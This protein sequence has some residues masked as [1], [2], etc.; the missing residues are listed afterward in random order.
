MGPRQRVRS[1]GGRDTKSGRFQEDVGHIWGVVPGVGRIFGVF[2]PCFCGIFW[3]PSPVTCDKIL[4][5]PKLVVSICQL[6]MSCEGNA[7]PG[8]ISCPVCSYEGPP[9][10]VN[11]H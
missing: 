2:S 5:A 6:L 8:N 1:P 11:P 10:K 7:D 4:G 3:G 9:P